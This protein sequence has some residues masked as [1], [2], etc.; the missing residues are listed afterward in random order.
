MWR[1]KCLGDSEISFL[2]ICVYDEHFRQ[3]LEI[4]VSAVMRRFLSVPVNISEDP[5]RFLIQYTL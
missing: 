4:M 1:S 5:E 3:L 2:E